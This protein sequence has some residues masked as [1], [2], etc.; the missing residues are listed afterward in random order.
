MIVQL[1]LTTVL[2]VMDV[3]LVYLLRACG[4]RFRAVGDEN[5]QTVRVL[6]SNAT[7][8]TL[9]GLRPHTVYQFTVLARDDN[10]TA[11]FSKL[12]SATTRSTPP[13]YS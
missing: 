5:W 12:T 1:S 11:R 9:H 10:G 4:R 6:P 3:R 8:L 7:S 2:M 13:L